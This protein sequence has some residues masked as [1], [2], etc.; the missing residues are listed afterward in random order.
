MKVL[1]T[2]DLYV[3]STNGVATSVRNLAEELGMRGHDVR[4]LT[5]SADLHSRRDENVYYIR[6]VSMEKVYP[7]VRG[8]LSFRNRYL[9]E[10]IDWKPDVIHSQCEFFSFQFAVYISAKTGTPIVHTY[11]TLYEQYF[12]YL[13]PSET[14]G[15]Y[16]IPRISKWR[17]RHTAALISPTVKTED[18]LRG[19]GISKPIH[20]VPTGISLDQH[21]PTLDDDRR[22]EMRSRFGIGRDDFVL[23]NL[24]R[25]GAEKNI[26]ELIGGTAMLIS[27]LQDLKLLIVGGGPSA[28]DLKKLSL[29]L[30]ISDRVIFTGMVDPSLVQYYYHMG[31]V[32][33]SAS[34]SETQGL[35][36]IEAAANGLPLVCR[37]DPCLEGV[38]TDGQNGFVYDDLEGFKTAVSKL[39]KDRELRLVFAKNSTQAAGAFDKH[40][41]ADSVEQVYE[42]VCRQ[43]RVHNK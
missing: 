29:Q 8:T 17:L 9:D 41:F 23:I 27:E 15:R 24:G 13:F 36:Y 20:V 19:Y 11:H 14:V 4:I 25:I 43:A 1:I 16:V 12:G 3:T 5:L 21:L 34:T 28:E 30:G 39:Y 22:E 32:F 26:E 33:V 2:T 10:L 18:V 6:S 37:R 31:D 38:L 42:E 35:T 7:N 40:H